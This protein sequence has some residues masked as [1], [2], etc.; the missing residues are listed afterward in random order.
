MI[1]LENAYETIKDLSEYAC[2]RNSDGCGLQSGRT[3]VAP[4]VVT[5]RAVKARSAM[6]RR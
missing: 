3:E 6:K 5:T 2:A 4:S 1:C